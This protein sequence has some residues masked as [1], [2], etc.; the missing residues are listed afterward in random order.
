MAL[1]HDQQTRII[2]QERKAASALFSSPANELV[3]VF[4]VEGG[5]APGGHGQRLPLEDEGIAQMLAH[6]GHVVEVMVFDDS[7]IAACDLLRRGQQP[8]M[9]MFQNVLFVIRNFA[10]FVFTHAVSL[11]KSRRNVPQKVLTSLFAMRASGETT[12]PSKHPQGGL[13]RVPA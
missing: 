13:N 7:L 11:K 9:A 2:G 4:D 1:R 5:G 3:P 8:N 12:R 10:A 6:Q